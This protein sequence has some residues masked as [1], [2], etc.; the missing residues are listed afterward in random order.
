MA[1]NPTKVRNWLVAK[2]TPAEKR[3]RDLLDRHGVKYQFQKKYWTGK[4]HRF[5]DFWLFESLV[6]LEV[7]GNS[8]SRPKNIIADWNRTVELVKTQRGAEVAR[9]FNDEVMSPGFDIERLNQ[10]VFKQTKRG[11]ICHFYRFKADCQPGC[12]ALAADKRSEMPGDSQ[13]V[14]P[15]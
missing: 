4:Q 10:I 15:T 12:Q 6:F 14:K 2:I 5:V 11:L 9:V 1:R 13:T 8:H 7:D 3:V